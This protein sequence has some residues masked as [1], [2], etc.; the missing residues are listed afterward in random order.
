MAQID[1]KSFS[2]NLMFVA[3]NKIV[4]ISE[5]WLLWVKII[6]KLISMIVLQANKIRQ[7]L[8]LREVV[9]LLRSDSLSERSTG[10]AI[11]E[12]NS[13]AFTAAF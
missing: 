7:T 4:L 8:E 2:K 6:I 3:S 1:S 5:K 11:S 9:A 12:M 13:I 10:V